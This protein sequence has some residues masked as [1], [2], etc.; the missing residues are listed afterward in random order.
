[1]TIAWEV[2]KTLC[3]ISLV[4]SLMDELKKEEMAEERRENVREAIL[5]DQESNP[6]VFFPHARPGPLPLVP[7]HAHRPFR[8]RNFNPNPAQLMPFPNV[9]NQ[10]PIRGIPEIARAR[11]QARNL[12]LRHLH[13]VRLDRQQARRVLIRN[14]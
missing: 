11:I 3:Q 1:M 9:F 13:Q 5:R 10:Q 4:G 2:F 6:E 7:A 12:N 8:N 14:I